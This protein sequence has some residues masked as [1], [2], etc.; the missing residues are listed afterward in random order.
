[1]AKQL[2]F[3][4]MPK[5]PRLGKYIGKGSSRVAFH[6]GRD[7]VLKI[8]YN[9]VGIEQNKEEVR[10]SAYAGMMPLAKILDHAENFEWVLQEKAYPH[11]I[12]KND[13]IDNL[14]D[15]LAS[16]CSD[17]HMDNV[18][19]IKGRFVAFDYGYTEEISKYYSYQ[20][21]DREMFKALPQYAR[22]NQ[23]WDLDVNRKVILD[24]IADYYNEEN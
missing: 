16:I 9:K 21:T 5:K 6:S 3:D 12:L 24:R 22:I 13:E 14:S 11:K 7:T 17:L 15:K 20:K 8:A 4:W 19:F 10:L 2:A 18:G 1:M 23:Q